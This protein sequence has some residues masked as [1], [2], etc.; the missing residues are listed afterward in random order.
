MKAQVSTET[1][2]Q[3]EGVRIE[4]EGDIKVAKNIIPNAVYKMRN[5]L[6]K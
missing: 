1:L 4:F 2:D 6:K 5:V 3:M